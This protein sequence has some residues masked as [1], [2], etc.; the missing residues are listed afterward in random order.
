MCQKKKLTNKKKQ[1]QILLRNTHSSKP[2]KV[3]TVDLVGPWPMVATVEELKEARVNKRQQFVTSKKEERIQI[4]A[5]AIVNEATGWPKTV[6][7]ENK[8]SKNVALVL[9]SE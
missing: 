2:F 6:P 5:L 1:G 4:W 3:L 9:D 8:T 7:P